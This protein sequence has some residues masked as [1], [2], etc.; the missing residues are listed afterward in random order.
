MLGLRF[1][2]HLVG[3][4]GTTFGRWR[5]LGSLPAN[6]SQHIRSHFHNSVPGTPG[7]AFEPI[8]GGGGVSIY[9]SLPTWQSVYGV[10][11]AGNQTSTTMRNQPDISF[12]ASNGWWGHALV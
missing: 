3:T 11:L 1:R 10:G 4:S 9:N 8:G 12:F 2:T 6:L 5:D 7:L